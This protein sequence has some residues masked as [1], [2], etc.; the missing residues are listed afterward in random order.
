MREI[1]AKH[2]KMTLG[3]DGRRGRSVLAK[4]SRLCL[5]YAQV[6]ELFYMILFQNL[7][8]PVSRF[9]SCEGQK[10]KQR[11]RRCDMVNGGLGNSR[12][13]RMKGDWVPDDGSYSR[14]SLE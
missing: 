4:W 9:L 12:A 7:L 14:P 13:I 10:R 8:A 6:F 2:R 3:L 11:R 1:K 5:G